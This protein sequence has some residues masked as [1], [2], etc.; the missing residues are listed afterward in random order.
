MFGVVQGGNA[1]QSC[2]HASVTKDCPNADDGWLHNIAGEAYVVVPDGFAAL[3]GLEEVEPKTVKNRVV[4]L[5]RHRERATPS[6]AANTFR[7]EIADGRR[8]EGVVFPR[9]A[10]L[11]RRPS[12]RG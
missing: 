5:G 12:C 11:G 1:L 10:D 7:A 2:H 3:A 4:R 8:V 9:G 6:G